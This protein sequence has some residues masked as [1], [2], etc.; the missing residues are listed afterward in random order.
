MRKTTQIIRYLITSFLILILALS[1]AQTSCAQDNLERQF[2]IL[3][4][5]S[6]S[7]SNATV[8]DQ[9]DGFEKGLEGINA[10]ITYE[11]MNSD[12][13]Y[14]AVDIMNFD[15]YLKYKVF[16]ARN[17]DLVVVA[18]DLALRYAINNRNVMFPDLPIVFMGINNNPPFF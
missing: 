9:L 7:Y 12:V 3:F 18:D 15:K 8:P 17:F 6:Y 10:E 4:I 16:S 14:G 13:Y 2:R 11:F 5:S 1:C